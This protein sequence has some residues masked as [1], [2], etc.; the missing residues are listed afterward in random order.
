MCNGVQRLLTLDV[1]EISKVG[2]LWTP[3]LTLP[4]IPSILA[5]KWQAYRPAP[6]PGREGG[7]AEGG[8]G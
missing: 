4:L 5:F 7:V 6:F 2:S 3:D 1:S 8:G